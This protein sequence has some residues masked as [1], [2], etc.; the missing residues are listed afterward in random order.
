[1]TAYVQCAS[2]IAAIL[3]I[4]AAVVFGFLASFKFGRQLLEKVNLIEKGFS[5][6]ELIIWLFLSLRSTR[7]YSPLESLTT[8]APPKKN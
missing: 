5:A 7:R 2:F 1:M 8:R 6:A 4:L 3:M